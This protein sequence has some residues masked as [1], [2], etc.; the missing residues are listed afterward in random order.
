MLMLKFLLHV[1]VK[2]LLRSAEAYEA[3]HALYISP[4]L[5]RHARDVLDNVDVNVCTCVNR[6]VLRKARTLSNLLCLMNGI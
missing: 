4:A 6:K 3:V 1:A 2:C 5:F